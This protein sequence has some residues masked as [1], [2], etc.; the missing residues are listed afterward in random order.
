MKKKA[1]DAADDGK[2]VVMAKAGDQQQQQG[3]ESAVAVEPQ[4]D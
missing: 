4:L 3:L 2:D 1:A